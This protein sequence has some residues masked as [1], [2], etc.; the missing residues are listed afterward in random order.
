MR[1]CTQL[2]YLLT[3]F[4]FLADCARHIKAQLF[5][6]SLMNVCIVISIYVFLIIT[7]VGH[8]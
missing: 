6:E 3:I 1:L 8:V 4:I 5:D 7:K 2:F